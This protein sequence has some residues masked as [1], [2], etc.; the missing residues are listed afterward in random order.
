MDNYIPSRDA[1]MSKTRP[2]REVELSQRFW[3]L[4]WAE[5]QR[6]SD[7]AEERADG[8]V[9]N[10]ER[11]SVDPNHTSPKPGPKEHLSVI[12]R[13]SKPKDFVWT[14]GGELLCTEELVRTFEENGIT[15]FT[16]RPVKTQ[17]R[18]AKK[19]PIP[20]YRELITTGWA[21]LASRD[22][23][24]EL[25]KFCEGCKKSEYRI[26]DPS[27]LIDEAAW[28]GSDIFM[29][30]PL[31]KFR[32]VSERTVDLI[33]SKKITGV[34]IVPAGEAINPSSTF[35][36]GRLSWRMPEERA[37]QIGEPLGIY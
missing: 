14:W 32:F 4:R 33:R 20:N 30:W 15:G 18:S 13:T 6:D 23:G 9:Y 26:A 7:F 22:S 24:L 12:F 16:T 11:C 28:D 1:N 8:V 17:L 19:G 31:P 27:R 5:K 21:G 35:G 34:A 29:V 25:L 10:L 36:P 3:C 2:V 37:R